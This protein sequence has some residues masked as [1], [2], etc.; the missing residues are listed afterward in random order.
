MLLVARRTLKPAEYRELRA[1]LGLDADETHRLAIRL[2]ELRL[3]HGYSLRTLAEIC[4]MAGKGTTVGW[5]TGGMVPELH[6]LLLLADLY[7]CTLDFLLGRHDEVRDSWTVQEGKRRLRERLPT[8][9]WPQL[10]R[11]ARFQAAWRLAQE[12]A[13]TAFPPLRI[14]GLLGGLSVDMFESLL[15]G[16]S[17][18]SEVI[19]QRFAGALGIP[20]DLLLYG[21]MQ[22]H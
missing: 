17:P 14:S 21:K 12:V 11:L 6:V 18:P 20:V 8:V 13:P 9:K 15:N 19:L 22:T 4:G 2:R 3:E 5:E 10:T 7:G 16:T 1:K